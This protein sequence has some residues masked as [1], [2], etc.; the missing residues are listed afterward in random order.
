MGMQTAVTDISN[1][2]FEAVIEIQRTCL[3]LEMAKEYDV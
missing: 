1:N 3:Y 2:N